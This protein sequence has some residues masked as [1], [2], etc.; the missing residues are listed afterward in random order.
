LPEYIE[1]A[2]YLKENDFSLVLGK[3]LKN[4]NPEIS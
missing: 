1:A 2:N 4:N 3:V